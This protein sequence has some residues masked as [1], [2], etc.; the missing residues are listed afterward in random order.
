M[1]ENLEAQQAPRPGPQPQDAPEGPHHISA[2]NALLNYPLLAWFDLATRELNSL[3]SKY[4][5]IYFSCVFD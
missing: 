1:K 3:I 5:F 2:Q 4:L